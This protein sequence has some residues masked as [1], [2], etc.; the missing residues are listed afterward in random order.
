MMKKLGHGRIV[1]SVVLFER[2]EWMIAC[3]GAAVAAAVGCIAPAT[4]RKDL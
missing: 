3:W 2:I 1:R 4:R